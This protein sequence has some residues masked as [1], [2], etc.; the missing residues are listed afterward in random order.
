MV[1]ETIS[2]KLRLM[3]LV[4]LATGRSLSN[5]ISVL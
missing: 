2:K 4:T 5:R 3:H 1:P